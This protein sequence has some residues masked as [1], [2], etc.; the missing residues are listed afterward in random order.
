M[1]T[2]PY[3]R[4]SVIDRIP[5]RVV[6]SVVSALSVSLLLLLLLPSALR[7]QSDN[8][9]D[10][11]DLGWVHY[12]PIGTM[13]GPQLTWTV[14][15][16]G[17]RIQSA[18]SPSSG[19]VGPGRGGSYRTNSYTDFQVTVD[20][21]NWNNNL[22]Q[23]FGLFARMNNVG[24]TNSDGYTLTYQ[25]NDDDL[26]ISLIID[27]APTTLFTGPD[28]LTL[29]PGNS[30]RFVFLGQGSY[31]EGRVYQLP[32]TTNPLL[33]LTTTDTTYSSG[34]C[35]LLVYDNGGGTAATDVTFD[36]YQAMT[37]EP[38]KMDVFLAGGGWV[39]VTWTIPAPNYQLQSAPVLAPGAWT[40]I[41]P[42]QIITDPNRMRY[43]EQATSPAKFFR[44]LKP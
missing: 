34:V 39:N 32:N 21:I 38:P 24:L 10:G 4:W 20:V 44:L 8:F 9:D 6:L 25:A 5:R 19:L 2:S 3:S 31:L 27:E 23:A 15:N 7:A 29:V 28:N 30:Y 14:V 11:N 43:Q 42:L 36:N 18:P 12:D 13:F 17:Y 1:K 22:P 37:L 40:N 16:G 26:N 35:G 41:P 33:V